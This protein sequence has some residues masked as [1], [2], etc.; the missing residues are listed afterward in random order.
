MIVEHANMMQ[1][2]RDAHGS[3]ISFNSAVRLPSD[4]Q[5]LIDAGYN[6][7]PT[8]DHFFGLPVTIPEKE[9]V[10]ISKFG[11]IY[12]MS[13]GAVDARSRNI[14]KLYKIHMM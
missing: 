3:A 13:S 9:K 14:K 12:T 7:S 6:P 10:K 4:Y 8:S 11:S 1:I 2:I 5:R